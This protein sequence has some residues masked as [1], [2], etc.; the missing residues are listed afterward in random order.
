MTPRNIINGADLTGWEK[1]TIADDETRKVTVYRKDSTAMV[2]FYQT[3]GTKDWEN[4]FKAWEMAY[5]VGTEKYKAHAG[6]VSE[7]LSFREDLLDAVKGA[8]IVDVFGFSQGGAHAIL[9]TRD[10][11][12]NYPM[13]AVYTE[14]YGAPRVY[15]WASAR[16]FQKAFKQ[17]RFYGRVDQHRFHGDPVPHVPFKLMGYGDVGTIVYHGKREWPFNVGCHS[18]EDQ[19]YGGV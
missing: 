15:S 12:Y 1:L 11:W 3:R 13:T 18:M 19:Y 17:T 9:F 4:N 7:Y 14:T 16:E 8:D 2:G 6:F 10:V 5:S